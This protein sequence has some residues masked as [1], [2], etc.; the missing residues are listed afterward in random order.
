[1]DFLILMSPRRPEFYTILF[2]YYSNVFTVSHIFS[3]F[4]TINDNFKSVTY[5]HV[6]R[7]KHVHEWE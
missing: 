3:Y 7:F 2:F 6:N 4:C 1:M 5:Y